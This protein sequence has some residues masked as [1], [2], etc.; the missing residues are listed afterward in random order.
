M[1]G[2]LVLREFVRREA[3]EAAA[4]RTRQPCTSR[5]PPGD[6]G[7]VVFDAPVQLKAGDRLEVKL[8]RTV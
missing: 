8:R 3:L 1:G 5:S 7:I 4:D 2:S 6:A